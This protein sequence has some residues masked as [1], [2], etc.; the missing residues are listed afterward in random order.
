VENIWARENVVT[1]ETLEKAGWDGFLKDIHYRPDVVIKGK[2]DALFA[3]RQVGEHDIYFLYNAEKSPQTFKAEFRVTGKKIS[4]WDPMSGTVKGV[5]SY[6]DFADHTVVDLNLKP[7][8]SIF[9]IFDGERPIEK[10]VINPPAAKVSEMPIQ[11]AWTV[12]FDPEYGT[13]KTLEFKPL[14]D[15][16]DHGD[17]DVKH[18]SGPAIYKTQLDISEDFLGS[19]NKFTLDLGD[20]QVA[21]TVSVNGVGQGTSWIAPHHVDIS[22]A[23]KAGQNS[24]SITV[25][26]L[27]TNRLIGDAALPDVDGYEPAKWNPP[28]LTPPRKKM[29]EWYSNNELPNLG[30]RVTFTTANFYKPTDTLIPSGLIGPVRII[31]ST[32]E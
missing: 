15:W 16:K 8:E 3:H 17:V 9:V 6:S 19:G 18:Y 29:P 26:N 27:W 10:T 5:P 7:Q 12:S 14:I 11:S 32:D 25:E 28:S 22:N 4:L 24:I 31:A 2:P 1:S 21:A 13:D 20:V 30:Q 23:L